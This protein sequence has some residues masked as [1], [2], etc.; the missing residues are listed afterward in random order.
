MVPPPEIAAK[1]SIISEL[2]PKIST[3]DWKNEQ[4]DDQSIG[5]LVKL[6]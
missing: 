1:T 2:G 6:L 3:E 5:H 4:Q